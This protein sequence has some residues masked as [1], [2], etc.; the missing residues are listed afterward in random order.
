[1][2][3]SRS[4]FRQFGPHEAVQLGPALFSFPYPPAAGAP[5]PAVLSIGRCL[6]ITDIQYRIPPYVYGRG[7][8]R[9]GTSD[10]ILAAFAVYEFGGGHPYPFAVNLPWHPGSSVRH[11]VALTLAQF[12]GAPV[13]VKRNPG[14]VPQRFEDAPG[15]A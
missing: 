10:I 13:Q 14:T 12:E 4:R 6:R 2:L 8:V 1:M 3:G 11:A 9:P 5:H 15:P 7:G